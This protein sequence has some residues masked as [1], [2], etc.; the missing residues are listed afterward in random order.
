MSDRSKG[1]RNRAARELRSSRNGGSKQEK[2]D[3]TKRAAA[4][5]H[6]SENEMWLEGEKPRGGKG[7]RQ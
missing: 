3:N 2:A 5:K 6:L 1:M 4:Y 7:K